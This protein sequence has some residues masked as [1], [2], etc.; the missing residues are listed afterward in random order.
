MKE[1]NEQ[2][3]KAWIFYTNTYIFQKYLEWKFVSELQKIKKFY[4]RKKRFVSEL[5]Q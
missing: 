1:E 3:L 5:D 4:T 2:T